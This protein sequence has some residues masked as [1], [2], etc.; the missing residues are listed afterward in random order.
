VSSTVLRSLYK[1]PLFSRYLVPFLLGLLPLTW[2]LPSNSLILGQDSLTFFIHPFNPTVSPLVPYSLTGL[3]NYYLPD[4]YP[5]AG[6]AAVQYLGFGLIASE[7]FFIV[8][9]SEVASFGVFALLKLINKLNDVQP[10]QRL[11]SKVLATL[12]YLVNPFTLS[13]SWWRIEPWTFLWACVPLIIAVEVEIL[14]SPRPS[15][16]M[17]AISAIVLIIL[18]GGVFGALFISFLFSVLVALLF[19][20]SKLIL[21]DRNLKDVA[22]R[23]GLLLGFAASTLWSI[24]PFILLSD[25]V[26]QSPTGLY[27]GSTSG[28][29]LQQF[30][31]GSSSNSSL[32]NVLSLTGYLRLAPQYGNLYYAWYSYFPVLA[33]V[34]LIIPAIMCLYAFSC[35]RTKGFYFLLILPLSSVP[36]CVGSNAPFGGL[37]LFLVQSNGVFSVLIGGFYSFI[38][39]YLLGF[40]VA[41]YSLTSGLDRRQ[42]TTT[43]PRGLEKSYRGSI[44][45]SVRRHQDYR[46]RANPNLGRIAAVLC[47][48]LLVVV[49]VPFVTQNVYS[50]TGPNVAEFQLPTSFDSL[51]QYM[52][53]NYSG[54]FYYTLI[55]PMSAID[56]YYFQF[57]DSAFIETSHL[58]DSYVPYP[59]LITNSGPLATS[60]DNALAEAG[61]TNPIALLSAI[62]VKYVVFNPYYNT[63]A[64]FMREAPDGQPV[65]LIHL[66]AALNAT[67]GPPLL[68]GTFD[69]YAIPGVTPILQAT[70][71]LQTVQ[72]PTF[73][74]YLSFLTTVGNSTPALSDV[75]QHA[76]WS[77]L[78]VPPALTTRVEPV[79]PTTQNPITP[80]SYCAPYAELENG[81]LLPFG[82]LP[83]GFISPFATFINGTL[84]NLHTGQLYGAANYSTSNTTLNYSVGKWTNSINSSGY[85]Q[86]PNVKSVSPT[87]GLSA[88]L[89]F[90]QLAQR[91]WIYFDFTSG[92][93]TVDVVVYQVPATSN[94]NILMSPYNNGSLYAINNTAFDFPCLSSPLSLGV[95]ISSSKIV[96]TLSRIN[97]SY[98]RPIVDTLTLLRD[99][100][101]SN[102][103]SNLSLAP[104]ATGFPYTFSTN[105]SIREVGVTLSNLQISSGIPLRY[106]L[107]VPSN[108]TN[109]L[110]QAAPAVSGDNDFSLDVSES[111]PSV[112]FVT[113]FQPDSALWSLGSFPGEGQ[114]LDAGSGYNV[115][116]V[117]LDSSQLGVTTR[118]LVQFSNLSAVGALTSYIEISF[119]FAVILV[120]SS[121][122]LRIRL[123]QLRGRWVKS[124]PAAAETAS[125]HR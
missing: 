15:I 18:D 35:H 45:R 69:V 97:S 84:V 125:N 33:F 21:R 8:L 119:L 83:S 98:G 101:V 53:R 77:N 112:F 90:S 110:T 23:V 6:A 11:R 27:L 89:A 115:W 71:D 124:R 59:L 80:C 37:N 54:P 34:S 29:A 81:T 76:I 58:M 114:R 4:L 13:V 56:G 105:I 60:L 117:K 14:Y 87:A 41:A 28:P 66:Q 88:S 50:K 16:R 51:N 48:V 75:I 109:T 47:T 104:T 2:I 39:F 78:S 100:A 102:G 65:D 73:D 10:D 93:I 38:Q 111:E 31:M 74:S 43:T 79:V 116:Q 40:I 26:G 24:V 25:A 57:G 120:S 32:L 118:L 61:D 62:H 22:A 106:V 46:G 17:I 7:Y 9:I 36:L 42:V 12:L 85:L 20:A 67:V 113:L 1:H 86:L 64:W 19:L 30:L 99:N 3:F 72:T 44:D 49:A 95:N 5:T 52:I 107:T 94:C 103:F 63:T 108:L 96:A 70:T 91:N 121:K 68:V 122:R 55:L 123:K 92:N 82:D